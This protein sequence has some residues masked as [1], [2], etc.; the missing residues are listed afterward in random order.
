MFLL[1]LAIAPIGFSIQWIRA[2][3]IDFKYIDSITRDENP[4]RFW[5]NAIVGIVFGLIFLVLIT[6]I[7]KWK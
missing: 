5:F 2:G 3:K 4:I 1:V 7:A 6:L